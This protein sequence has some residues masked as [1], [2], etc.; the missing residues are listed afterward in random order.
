NKHPYTAALRDPDAPFLQ[1][2]GQELL[3]I[4]RFT[5]SGKGARFTDYWFDIDATVSIP[6]T[7]IAAGVTPYMPTMVTYADPDTGLT[8]IILGGLEGV[9]TALDDGNGFR[10]TGEGKNYIPAVGNR[11]GN[12]AA[13]MLFDG[14]AQPSILAADIAQALFYGTSVNGSF[15]SSSSFFGTGNIDWKLQNGISR[16]IQIDPSG[17][18]IA[19]QYVLPPTEVSFVNPNLL[20]SDF[21]QLAGPGSLPIGR[22]TGLLQAPENDNPGVSGQWP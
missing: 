17:S 3:F 13:G 7:A 21:F 18:G 20:P 1:P 10:F 9:Y 2:S 15:S 6:T 4:D 14:A 19:Y 12:I 16:Q 8:R 5:N 11:S 22:T